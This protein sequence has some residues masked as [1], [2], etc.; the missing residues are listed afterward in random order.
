M[1]SPGLRDYHVH[2]F[3]DGCAHEEMTLANI[4]REAARLGIEEVC[5]VKHYSHELPNG[6]DSWVFWKRINPDQYASFL[7]DIRAYQASSQI[8]MLAG[9]ETEIVD[10]CGKVNIPAEEA[11]RLDAL[12]LSVH[13]LPRMKILTADPAIIPGNI[14]ESPPDIVAD[15][16]ESIRKCGVEAILGNFVEAYVR[17]MEHNPRVLVL[18]HMIDGLWPL[19]NY[20]VPVDD[21][22]NE[23]LNALMEPLMMACAE[24][25]V[26]WELTSESVKCVKRPSVLKRANAL[27]VRFSATADAHFLQ[28]DGWANLRDHSKAEEYIS[29]LGLAK[30]FIRKGNTLSRLKA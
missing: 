1:T 18:G 23:K 26:L 2:Y 11:A 9:V 27:G 12:I 19:R 7:K 6:K 21:L 24:K 30:S 22:S 4:E 16:R 5:V 14:A 28:T 17:A 13:W 8:R 10:D 15:W 20:E 25:Q 3:L 29:S